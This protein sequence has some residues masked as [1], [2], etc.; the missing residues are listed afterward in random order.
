M[1]LITGGGAGIGAALAHRLASRGYDLLLVARDPDRAAATARAVAD[2]HGVRA[3]VL[4]ADLASRHGL[5]RVTALLSGPAAPAVDVLVHDA[6]SE[7]VGP[8]PPGSVE[9]GQAEIDLCVTATMRLTHA[10]LPGMLRRGTGAVVTVGGPTHGPTAAWV[11]A[12]TGALAPTLAGTGVR[13]LA[14]G[15]DTMGTGRDGSGAA[16]RAVWPDADRVADTAL[17]DLDAGRAPRVPGAAHPTPSAARDRRPRE[18]PAPGCGRE[19]AAHPEPVGAGTAG[20]ATR[21]GPS[22][23]PDCPVRPGAG[24]AVVAAGD[25]GRTPHFLAGGP[26]TAEQ[27]ARAAAA[28]RDR[29]RHDRPVRTTGPV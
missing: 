9:A 22:R 14:A 6:G 28:A 10:V 16:G 20:P 11:A 26:R 4:A 15:P 29:A 23:L 7:A 17:A 13:A 21:R 1:A 27:R 19:P 12:F 8:Y 3:D 18:A 25:R 2:R 24:R 5:F